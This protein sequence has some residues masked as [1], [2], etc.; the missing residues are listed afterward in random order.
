MRK[1]NNKTLMKVI[2]EG[3]HYGCIRLYGRQYNPTG[4]VP[5]QKLET[6]C[7]C[8]YDLETMG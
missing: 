4:V 6:I 8:V 2:G 7:M 3:N 1:A 5:S